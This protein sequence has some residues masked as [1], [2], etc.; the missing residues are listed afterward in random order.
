MFVYL[1]LSKG[2]YFGFLGECRVLQDSRL[3]VVKHVAI[4]LLLGLG[5]LGETLL[6]KLRRAHTI[7]AI[8]IIGGTCHEASNS[9][10]LLLLFGRVLHDKGLRAQPRTRLPLKF[11]HY[12][13]RA[14]CFIPSNT[15]FLL[16]ESRLILQNFFIESSLDAALVNGDIRVGQLHKLLIVLLDHLNRFA[17]QVIVHQ[18]SISLIIIM[19]GLRIIIHTGI[20]IF[21]VGIELLD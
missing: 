9:T 20:F 14:H 5:G 17:S 18:L 6:Q 15:T 10:C 3:P 7:I 16:M 2:T 19:F 12:L 1:S 4:V 8:I 21:G 13:H 11:A